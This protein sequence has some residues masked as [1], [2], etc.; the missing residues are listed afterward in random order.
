MQWMHMAIAKLN[1]KMEITLTICYKVRSN[2]LTYF[3]KPEETV[4]TL[5]DSCFKRTGISPLVRMY[6]PKVLVAKFFSKPSSSTSLVFTMHP[7]LF[8]NTWIGSLD[9]ENFSTNSQ[10]FLGWDMSKRWSFTLSFPE[11]SVISF[12]ASSP[13]VSLLQTMWT[14]APFFAKKIAASFPIP[15]LAPVIINDREEMSTSRA[16]G[17]KDFSA[18]R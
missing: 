4:T 18:A 15:L 8:I 11:T 5:G 13:L 14:V 9:D 10:T 17:S 12:L 6:V 1:L 7:A 2:I 3:Y 16:L